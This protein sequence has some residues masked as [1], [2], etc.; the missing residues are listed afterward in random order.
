[1]TPRQKDTS[2]GNSERSEKLMRERSIRTNRKHKFMDCLSRGDV[3]IG[4]YNSKA[5]G[6]PAY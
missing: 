6:R 3:S 2:S 1:M 5:Y 4:G